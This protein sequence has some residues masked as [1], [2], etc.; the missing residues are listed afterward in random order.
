MS[1]QISLG[2][3]PN[4]SNIRQHSPRSAIPPAA[5]HRTVGPAPDADQLAHLPQPRGRA[6][7]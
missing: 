3:R 6:R 1:G 4:D 7:A 2:A 5:S